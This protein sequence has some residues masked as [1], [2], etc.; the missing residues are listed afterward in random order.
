M[1]NPWHPKPKSHFRLFDQFLKAVA[2]CDGFFCSFAANFLS[3]KKFL[4]IVTAIL[5]SLS[6]FPQSDIPY[7]PQSVSEPQDG[8]VYKLFPTSNMWT[9]LK[10]DT[11]NGRI[12]QVQFSVK[13]AEYRFE[14]PL[15][16]TYLVETGKEKNGRFT[17]YPTSNFYNFILLDQIDGRTWQVQ[18]G[19]EP[20]DR[21]VLRIEWFF[22]WAT[23][24]AFRSNFA[25]KGS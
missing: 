19:N 8:A 15:S 25:L 21:A 12:W 6:A 18:W 22:S 7:A 11:R 5:L 3:M 9:F 24:H 4:F 10:L 2:V 16:T 13:G 20:K 23:G 1:T 14:T 17:L